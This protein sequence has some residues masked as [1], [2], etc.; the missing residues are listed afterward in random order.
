MEEEIKVLEELVQ[1]IK[2]VNEHT[3]DCEIKQWCKEKEA[4]ENLIKG[5]RGLKAKVKRYEKYL[6]N[7]DKKFE[8]ALEYEY[9]ERETDY[10]PK[11]KIKEKIE[12]WKQEHYVAGQHNMVT[13]LQELMEDK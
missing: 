13:L 5:Y 4:I 2:R 9:R 11:S 3:L 8:E 7:K 12:Y 10:I 1:N 6:E